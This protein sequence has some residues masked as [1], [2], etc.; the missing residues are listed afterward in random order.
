MRRARVVWVG[1]LA[2]ALAGCVHDRPVRSSNFFDRLRSGPS[3]P[4]AVFIEY[5]LIER[6]AG[7]PAVNRDVWANVDETILPSD[8]RALLAENGLRVGVVGGLLPSELEAMI[9]NPKSSLGHRQRRLYV[10]NPAALTV[11]GPVQSAEYQVRPSLEGTPTTVK[12]EQAKFTLTFTPSHAAEGITLRCVPEVEYQDGKHFLP[13]GAAGAG[14]EA[15][16]PVEK[17]PSL[18]WEVTLS[19]RQFLVIG[20]D[21]DRGAWLG[22]QLFADTRGAAKVQRLLV[23]RTGRVESNSDVQP[24]TTK[25]GFV[26]LVSQT[27]ISAARGSRP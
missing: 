6:P 20:T 4:D 26:P 15:G 9:A 19:P 8:T 25:D 5:A 10:N 14:W 12:F 24:P 2:F 22:N 23:V 21:Y 16:K 3:G 17:Y 1:L 7:A 18:A 27:S 11:N 13:T